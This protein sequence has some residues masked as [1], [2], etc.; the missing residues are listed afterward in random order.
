MSSCTSKYRLVVYHCAMDV[1][2][3][4]N[5]STPSNEPVKLFVGQE[6]ETAL[7]IEL[8]QKGVVKNILSGHDFLKKS[9]VI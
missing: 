2:S 7:S 4:V 5:G 6:G 8:C 9:D 3:M 1:S